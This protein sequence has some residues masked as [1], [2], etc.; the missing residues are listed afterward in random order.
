MA[1]SLCYCVDEAEEEICD[2]EEEC[3]PERLCN[4]EVLL[5]EA[6]FSVVHYVDQR[7]VIEVEPS[8]VVWFFK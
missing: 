5:V 1:G 8:W 6:L 2:D 3:S 7:R 4:F